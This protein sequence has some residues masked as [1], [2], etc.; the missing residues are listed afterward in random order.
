MI[1]NTVEVNDKV[2]VETQSERVKIIDFSLWEL[3]SK[4][5]NAFIRYYSFD[6]TDFVF[7]SLLGFLMVISELLG[8]GFYLR[9]LKCS[10]E[11]TQ[12][13]LLNILNDYLSA[14]LHIQSST[15]K[16]YCKE[17]PDNEVLENEQMSS[18]S[19]HSRLS[20]TTSSKDCILTSL[21]WRHKIAI[22][23]M[24][25]SFILTEHTLNASCDHWDEIN[26]PISN[27][28]ILNYFL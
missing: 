17:V 21:S 4:A 11:H 15:T 26:K 28:S 5:V 1:K 20:S 14:V 7:I 16:I 19:Y 12:S 2:E 3:K 18:F 25:T 10:N 27:F 22:Q 8:F 6:I 24:V 13:R 9:H 23:V